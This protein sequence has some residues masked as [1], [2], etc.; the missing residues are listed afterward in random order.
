MVDRLCA[1]LQQ[2]L[3]RIAAVRSVLQHR[4]ELAN[5]I[6]EAIVL[7]AMPA[8]QWSIIARIETDAL[9][10]RTYIKLNF[11]PNELRLP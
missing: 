4:V 5:E 3:D 10:A 1:K 9:A 11:Q 8:A 2:C 7:R 6:T